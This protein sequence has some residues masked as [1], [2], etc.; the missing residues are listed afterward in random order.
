MNLSYKLLKHA[1]EFPKNTVHWTSRIKDGETT[2]RRKLEKAKQITGKANL[3]RLE[4]RET[5]GK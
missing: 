4:I 5:S 2:S 3:K 1:Q